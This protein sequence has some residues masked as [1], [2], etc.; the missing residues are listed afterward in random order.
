VPKTVLVVEDDRCLR[1]TFEAMVEYL[2]YQ[3][4]ACED[5]AQ[6]LEHINKADAVITD[7]LMPRLNG[8]ELT[9]EAKRQERVV[10]VL[11]MT[12]TPNLVPS[13]HLADKV[14]KKGN[15]SLEDIR[16]WLAEVLK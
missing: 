16:S 5:G 7:F 4:I 9:M 1:E 10:P 11:L 14:M 3:V 12:C 6:A 8:V 13:G 2:G 15:I